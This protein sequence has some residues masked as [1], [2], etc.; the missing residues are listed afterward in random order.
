LL[1]WTRIAARRFAL[2]GF[3]APEG[4]PFALRCADA[5]GGTPPNDLVVSTAP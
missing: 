2:T 1:A 3:L 5:G 4:A